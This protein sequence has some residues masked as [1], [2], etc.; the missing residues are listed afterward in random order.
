ML[1]V[2]YIL[3][4]VINS[5]TGIIL[6][7]FFNFGDFESRCSYIIVLTKKIVYVE[8]LNVVFVI[9]CPVAVVNIR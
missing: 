5:K 6:S 9:R 3:P 8:N 1:D 7:L 4:C 2:P